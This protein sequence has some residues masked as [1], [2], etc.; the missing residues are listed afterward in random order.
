MVRGADV[1][2]QDVGS[3]ADVVDYL[4]LRNTLL[5]VREHSGLYHATIRLVIA[6]WQLG[7]GLV[8]PARRG[9]YW[10]PR[11][12][13][14]AIADHLRRRYGPGAWYE[15]PSGATHAARFDVDSA[16]IELWFAPSAAE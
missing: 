1:R 15:I 7:A 16:E 6:L 13:L 10:S 3:N 2:N 14:R 9:P 5:M 8:A 4:Q 12:R 11:A